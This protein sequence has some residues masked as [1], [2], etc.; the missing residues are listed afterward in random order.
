MTPEYF[1]HWVEGMPRCECGARWYQT[2][3]QRLRIDHD[4]DKHR[5][6]PHP[7]SRPTEPSFA[8]RR[9]ALKLLP[10]ATLPYADD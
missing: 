10:A 6:L 9:E 8:E 4:Y 3:A 2:P 7:E 5:A 1:S